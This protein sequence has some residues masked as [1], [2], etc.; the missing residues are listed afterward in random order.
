MSLNKGVGICFS[1]E[2]KSNLSILVK[3]YFLK[4]AKLKFNVFIK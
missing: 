2:F 3:D 4:R 1:L